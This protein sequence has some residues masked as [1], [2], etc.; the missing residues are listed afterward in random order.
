[1]KPFL[2]VL[3]WMAVAAQAQSPIHYDLR[4]PQPGAP[5]ISV[6]I[7]LPEPAKAPAS[8]VMPRNYPGGYQQVPY[9]SF[10]TAV[11]AF[12]PDNKPVAAAK[13]SD[14]PRWTLGHPGETVQR[15]EYRV[16][17][18]RME[19]EIHDAVSTS[20]IRPRYA[21]LLGY[22]VFAYI[23]GFADRR[24]ELHVE[25]PQDW[26]VVTTLASPTATDFET[27]ADSEILMGPDLKVSKLP[28]KIPLVMAIY[29]EGPVEPLAEGQLAREA[30]DRVQAY[31]GDTPLPQYTVQLELLKPLPGHAYN[32]SQ[33][34]TDSGTFS[35]SVNAAITAQSTPTQRDG[36][37][38]NY[39]HHMAHCWIPKRA[40]GV[41]Y[42]PFTW[43]MTP[44]IDT[45]WFNEGF[46]RYAA[47]AA[48]VDA[49]P[50]ADGKAFRDWQLTSL[51]RVV[52]S[53][54][55][56]LRRMPLDVL[57]REASFL[58]MQDFRTGMN[59][60][61]RGTLMAAEMDDRI[62]E[63]TNGAKSLRDALRWLLRWSADN[64]RPFQPEDLPAYFATATGVDTADILAR[65]MKP[66]E[67]PQAQ[68]K[69]LK[70]TI[71]STMLADEGIGE[72]GFAAL[73]EAD[74][75]Q[76]LVDT[77]AH[78][79]TVLDNARDLKIDLS[80]VRDVVLTHFHDDH[81]GGLMTLRAEMRKR[82][83]A[84]LSRVHVATGLFY[85]RP[86]ANGVEGNSMIAMKPQYEATGAEFIEHNSLA[87]ILPGVFL[88]G[89]IPRRYAERNWSGSGKVRTPAGL[90]EDNVPDDQSLVVNTAEGLVV[91]TG[92]GHA[93]IVNILTFLDKRFERRPAIAVIGGLHLFAATDEQ[94]DW[95]AGKMKSF[96]VRYLLGA[97]C[98][99]IESL[100]RL[101]NGIGLSRQTA[102]V[103]AVGADFTLGEGIHPGRIAR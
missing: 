28:G 68:V 74:G 85:S 61:S 53:A 32:F 76:I 84:A 52:D 95:S 1:M 15:I 93:G 14:G 24:I 30:L 90:F 42:R 2:G 98:T 49:M 92:C 83:P 36:R 89:P 64:Q 57:S 81:T 63:R 13:D 45:I 3:L 39:A 43:E 101:R 72:W 73:V 71:L 58:Y 55:P 70:V 23:D 102:V 12:S 33:E 86:G 4:Y 50:P 35:L 41:G 59:V 48:T 8:L 20:K 6:S 91:I 18:A 21:G 56:F 10:V 75:Q 25:G 11:A 87:E 31:F 34:H 51:R 69:H 77:G 5:A 66:F 103:G 60:F 37:R 16:D 97:H 94:V 22:S 29:A 78:P 7:A 88:T 100:Y 17:I 67:A 26:P 9:D 62:R 47:I 27:L 54:P 82:N 65:W 44:V 46:G 19:S 80:H 40:Y 99:G 38:F 96:G 79:Q